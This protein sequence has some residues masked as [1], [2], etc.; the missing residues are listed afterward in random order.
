[1]IHYST[2]TTSTAD[3]LTMPGYIYWSGEPTSFTTRSFTVPISNTQTYIYDPVIYTYPDST[4][5]PKQHEPQIDPDELE[6]FLTD[7]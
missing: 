1:M 3:T 5:P 4:P 7:R 6:A 2:Y